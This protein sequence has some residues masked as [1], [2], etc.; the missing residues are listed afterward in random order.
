MRRISARAASFTESVIREMNR[1]AVE[2]GAVGL[3][4]G[5]P[6]FPAPAE[7]ILRTLRLRLPRMRQQCVLMSRLR[8]THDRRTTSPRRRRSAVAL[9]ITLAMS[10]LACGETA[11]PTFAPPLSPNPRAEP[12]AEEMTS[13]LRFRATFG[14]RSDIAW[15]RAVFNDP[16][17]DDGRTF[18]VPLL[19]DEVARVIAG[20]AAAN[21]TTDIVA[22]YGA[23]VPEDWAGMFVD[24]QADGTVVARFKANVDEHRLALLAWLPVGAKVEVRSAAWTDEELRGFVAR[25]EQEHDWFPTIGTALFTVEISVHGGLGWMTNKQGHLLRKNMPAVAYRV[26]AFQWIGDRRVAVGEALVTVPANG[27]TAI[28]LTIE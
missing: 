18:G 26:R 25:V 4:Q 13:A 1:L 28:R 14:L 16:G 12:T 2:A 3:A 24:Q 8:R 20:Q 22:A 7:L 19:P 15:I 6:D 27:R 5:F 23:A 9:S 17:S 11:Q 21:A 10:L